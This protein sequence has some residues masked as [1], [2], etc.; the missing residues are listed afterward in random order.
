MAGFYPRLSVHRRD[1]RSELTE[2]VYKS[3]PSVFYRDAFNVVLTKAGFLHSRYL[4]LYSGST[5]PEEIRNYID[6]N[7]NCE[8]LA[9]AMMVANYTKVETGEPANPTYVEGEV[10]DKGLFGGISTKSGHMD[11]RSECLDDLIGIYERQG[12]GNPLDYSTSLRDYSWIHHAPGFWWQQRP[13]NF[14]EWL[15]LGNVFE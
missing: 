14:F 3:W 6:D 2:Y 7:M 11:A 4:E 10:T 13:S 9:M 5:H 1:G 12:W 8:D 15:G